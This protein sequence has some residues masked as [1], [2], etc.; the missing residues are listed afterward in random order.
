MF[1]HIIGVLICLA[2]VGVTSYSAYRGQDFIL[3]GLFLLLAAIGYFWTPN[4][5]TGD[6]FHD[7]P[8]A[9]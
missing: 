1:R 3:I 9:N 5:Y 8:H 6:D 4:S 2:I 7:S